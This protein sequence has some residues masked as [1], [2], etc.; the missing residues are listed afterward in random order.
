MKLTNASI[1]G[2][3][4]KEK[5]YK[6]F[7]G[8]GMYL[9][10]MPNGGKYWRFKYRYAGGEK[11]FSIGIY[12]EISLK[13]ARTILAGIRRQLAMGIDPNKA[14]RESKEEVA[15]KNEETFSSISSE[16]YE[17]NLTTWSDKTRKLILKRIQS[18]LNSR[19]GSR[20]IS[21]ITAPELLKT[22]RIIEERSIEA[23]H[24][25]LQ[26]CGQIFRYA[27][28]T[29]RLKSDITLSLVGALSK[30]TT[31]HYA[32][33]TEKELY[34]FLVQLDNHADIQTKLALQLLILTFVRSTELM[35]AKWEEI[36]WTKAEWR[37]PAER[38]KMQALHIVPLSNQAIKVLRELQARTG[39]REY[40]LPSAKNLDTYISENILLHAIY[41]LGYKNRTT[42]H[43][44]RATASTI[45]NENGFPA[46]VIERQLAH[47]ER[48]KVRASYNHAQYLP[49]RR[50]ML[51]W[52]GDFVNKVS[53]K[54]II[55]LKERA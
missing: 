28:A 30:T 7:D 5:P 34:G 3:Q 49:D 18:D 24:R 53:G 26:L 46:D 32:S 11:V 17:R 39:N 15:L 1:I 27:I 37:I 40:I 4:P 14:K 29:G 19:L 21:E 20:P 51:Q 33:L 42:I 41:D 48:N 16:W 6:L 9:H 52:W 2:A 25:T 8:E 13:S 55:K 47:T 44:F 43:G 50:K 10:V 12:P 31:Q 36:D 54:N 35:G 45:L 23:A 22:L 38:M